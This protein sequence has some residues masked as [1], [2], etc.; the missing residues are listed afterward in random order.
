[1]KQAAVK[2]TPEILHKIEAIEKE[3]MDLKLSV[4]K[5]LTP[6]GKKGISFKGILKG[7]DV[8]DVD[9]STAKKS[10]YGKTGI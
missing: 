4:L 1:M 6:T 5:K 7:V 2:S 3:L 10:L 9:V 8:S